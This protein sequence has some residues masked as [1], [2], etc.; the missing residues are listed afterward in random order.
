MKIV[1]KFCMVMKLD[2]G[3]FDH[4]CALAKNFCDTNTDGM[5]VGTGRPRGPC[6][7]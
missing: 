7:P 6:L 5:G 3:K 2:E 1:S 4:A